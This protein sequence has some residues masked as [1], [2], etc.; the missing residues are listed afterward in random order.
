MNWSEEFKPDTLSNYNHIICDTPLGKM[1][2]EWKGWKERTTY[3]I[4]ID[5]NWIG[6]DDTMSGAR[7]KSLEYLVSKSNDLNSFIKL[8]DNNGDIEF[9][10]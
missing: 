1:I 8:N 4:S 10:D 7:E 6:S 3:D 9:T 2:I 5:E